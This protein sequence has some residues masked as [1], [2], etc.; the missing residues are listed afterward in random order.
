M[1]SKDCKRVEMRTLRSSQRGKPLEEKEDN[2]PHVDKSINNCDSNEHHNQ[3]E[4]HKEE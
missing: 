1:T 3:I 2:P 4:E